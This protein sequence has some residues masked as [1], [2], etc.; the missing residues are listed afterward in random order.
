MSMRKS[1]ALRKGSCKETLAAYTFPCFADRYVIADMD[2]AKKRREFLE[3]CIKRAGKVVTLA[4][5]VGS[6]P[7]YISALRNE[8]SRSKI[9]D[10]MLKRLEDFSGIKYSGKD[11]SCYLS[12]LFE[13]LSPND[14]EE[15]FAVIELKLDRMAVMPEQSAAYH[16]LIARIKEKLSAGPQ[17]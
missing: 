6:N 13:A 3:L 4:E 16:D 2:D 11:D 7:D 17:S 8:G 14:R 1:L 12:T 9:S 10:R 15:I 5:G